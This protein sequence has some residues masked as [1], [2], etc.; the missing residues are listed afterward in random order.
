MTPS[1]REAQLHR[2]SPLTL[3]GHC[4]GNKFIPVNTADLASNPNT[5]NQM[6]D[7]DT[8]NP[9]KASFVPNEIGLTP[10]GSPRRP[11]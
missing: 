8:S 11:Q 4:P 9:A 1:A 10:P 2:P 7:L 5:K 3:R 6:P